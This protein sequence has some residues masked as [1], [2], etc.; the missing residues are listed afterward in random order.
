MPVLLPTAV[1]LGQV[2]LGIG[3]TIS[4]NKKKKAA[5][6]EYQNSP[7]Q[8]PE[9]QI[10][11]TNIAGKM[12]QGTKL[13]AQ[14]LMEER[15]ASGAAQTVAQARKAATSPSQVQ[16]STVLSYLAQQAAQQDID[17]QAA[18]SWQQRQAAY[19]NALTSLSPYEEKRWQYNTLFPVQA[20]LNEASQ[21]GTVGMQN[22][23]QGA[24]SALSMYA[25]QQYLNSLNPTSQAGA[26]G[27]AQPSF[28]QPQTNFGSPWWGG[29]QPNTS[30]QQRQFG[31][32]E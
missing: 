23:G 1:A 5:L 29:G 7:Y 14:E 19:A 22:I 9:S 27:A 4:A 16:Q 32:P 10:R 31:F 2:G 6:N 15:L 13:P 24:S 12:A 25:N 8:I 18:E 30:I 3:Q 21:Q 20:K 17:R 26:A 11:A 28:V